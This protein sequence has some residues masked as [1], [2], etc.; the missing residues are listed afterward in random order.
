MVQNLLSREKWRKFKLKWITNTLPTGR[1]MTRR[2][3]RFS[4]LCPI[5]LSNEEHKLH[6]IQCPSTSS[7]EAWTSSLSSLTEWLKDQQT[8]PQ[9]TRSIIRVLRLCR[10]HG[11]GGRNILYDV[12]A[13][14]TRCLVSQASIGWE[15][16]LSG[17]LSKD[18]ARIQQTYY[19]SIKSRKTG[20]RWAVRLSDKLWGLLFSVWKH[21]NTVLHELPLDTLSGIDNLRVAIGHEYQLGTHNLPPLFHHYLLIPASSILNNSSQAMRQWLVLVRRARQQSGTIYTDQISSSQ[22]LRRWI[23]L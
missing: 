12:S 2:A 13:S 21:R 9:L 22:A 16:F 3:H 14:V 4:G 11:G 17:L 8:Y 23:G 15:N 1:N 19:S 5:C 18:W 7:T 20:H 10:H 6:L